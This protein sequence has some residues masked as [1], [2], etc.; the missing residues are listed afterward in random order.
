VNVFSSRLGR[1]TVSDVE[2]LVSTSRSYAITGRLPKYIP[3]FA[4]ANPHWFAVHI[5]MPLDQQ[6]AVGDTEVSFSLMSVVKP[7]LLLYALERCGDDHV[8]STVGTQPSD[9]PFNSLMQLQADQGVPRNP[10]LNSGAIALCSLLP[11]HNGADRCERFRRWLNQQS[12][13]RLTL[14][15]GTLSSVKSLPN[16]QNRAIAQL[17]G[18]HGRLHSSVTDAI[19]TYERVCC[20][21]GTVADLG[22]LGMLLAQ[23]RATIQ[24]HYCQQVTALMLTCG[25]Y[26]ASSRFAMD[27]GLPSKSGV[28]GAILSILPREGAIACYSPPL[29]SIG[30]SA[31]GIYF[32]QKLSRQFHLSIFG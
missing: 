27:V 11:G 13:A 14:D 31:G 12:H 30:N 24:P 21:A 23:P 22:R 6:V 28:S 7:L 32:L 26:E 18:D 3:S 20:L 2:H 19:D 4:R 5:E 9:L 29:D 15:H 1:I 8:F 10:M 16:E 25:L 17:L